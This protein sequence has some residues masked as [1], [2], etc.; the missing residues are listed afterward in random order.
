MGSRPQGI[1]VEGTQKG[2]R[3]GRGPDVNGF[4]SRLS[5]QMV[6]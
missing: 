3:S 6:L 2:E 1:R 4:D 5:A